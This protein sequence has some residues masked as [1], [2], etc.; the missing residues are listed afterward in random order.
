MPYAMFLVKNAILR[1]TATTRI[2]LRIQL[3]Y[4]ETLCRTV[5]EGVL[6]INSRADHFFGTL[7]PASRLSNRR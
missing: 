4:R 5:I 7:K 3:T 1:T 2:P 6:K